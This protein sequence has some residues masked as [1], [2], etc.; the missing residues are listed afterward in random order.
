MDHLQMMLKTAEFYEKESDRLI[1][2]LEKA[3]SK[4][5]AAAVLNELKSLKSKILFEI[6]QIE[7]II[8]ENSEL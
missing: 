1:K 4:K 5:Q 8:E 2:K 6:T 3:K 7:K